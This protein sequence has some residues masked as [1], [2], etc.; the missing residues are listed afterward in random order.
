MIIQSLIAEALDR[1]KGEKVQQITIGLGYVALSL[2]DGR[3]GLAYVYRNYL[4]PTCGVLGDAGKLELQPLAEIISGAESDN[5]LTAALGM[6]AINALADPEEIAVFPEKEEAVSTFFTGQQVGMIGYF[7]P[8]VARAKAA[9]ATVYAFD[10]QRAELPEVYPDSEQE[11]HLPK[12]DKLVLSGTTLI[13]K[14][15]EQILGWVK[16]GAEIILLG[17]STPLYPQIFA[18]RGISLLA[19]SFVPTNLQGT[20]HKVVAQAGGGKQLSKV[21]NKVNLWLRDS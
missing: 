14:S 8:L 4:G 10:S 13:N 7:A 5:L 3:T 9:G 20:V 11:Q 21:V 19:G 6:A 15:L 16:P 12:C 1:A 17:Y 18:K 2:T